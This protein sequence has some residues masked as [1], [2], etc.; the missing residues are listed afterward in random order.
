MLT[1]TRVGV[2]AASL[3]LI[4]S[5]LAR[6]GQPFDARTFQQAQASDK[7]ILVDI[8]A[9]WCPTCKAQKPIV[10]EIEDRNP[11]L[12]VFDVDFDTAKDVLRQFH[13]QYQSTLIVFKGNK[14]V[15]RSIGDTDPV[16]IRNLIAKG[17]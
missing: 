6:A 13:V 7:T 1:R 5:A 12:L 4:L 8:S 14:E 17:F 11:Q 9:T 10:R 2:L 16:S 3:L 15:G